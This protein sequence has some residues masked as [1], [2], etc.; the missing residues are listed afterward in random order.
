MSKDQLASVRNKKIGFVFQQFNLLARTS[1]L[2]ARTSAAVV[3]REERGKGGTSR[4]AAHGQDQNCLGG[5]L[6]AHQRGGDH[7]QNRGAESG[8]LVECVIGI[9]SIVPIVPIVS[10]DFSASPRYFLSSYGIM[11]S[12]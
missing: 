2:V 7:E 4:E 6:G 3:F 1:A 5:R 8:V 10:I 11:E 9:D 12:N